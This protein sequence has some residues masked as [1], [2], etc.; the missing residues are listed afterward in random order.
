MEMDKNNTLNTD[1][2]IPPPPLPTSWL[3]PLHHLHG[4]TIYN[5]TRSQVVVGISFFPTRDRELMDP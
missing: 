3:L 2:I 1:W 4:A 5:F